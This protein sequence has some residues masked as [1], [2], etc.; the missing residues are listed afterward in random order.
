MQLKYIRISVNSERENRAREDEAQ[1]TSKKNKMRDQ[2]LLGQ[3]ERWIMP[4]AFPICVLNEDNRSQQNDFIAAC[5]DLLKFY[6]L[7]E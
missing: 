2:L 1:P 6:Q 7:P 3:I 4:Q 5:C